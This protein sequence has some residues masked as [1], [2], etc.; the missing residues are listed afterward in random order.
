M[1]GQ[2]IVIVSILS[3]SYCIAIVCVV[4]KAMVKSL[5][6]KALMVAIYHTYALEQYIVDSD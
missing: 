6:V 1:R 2:C 3:L 4:I 5:M